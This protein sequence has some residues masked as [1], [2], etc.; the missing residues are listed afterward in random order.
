MSTSV[1]IAFLV[2]AAVALL[3]TPL[4]RQLARN[5]GLV[6]RPAARKVH[7]VAVPYLGG[8]G[9]ASATLTGL[10]FAPGQGVQLGAVA[11]IAVGMCVV[12]LLDDDR[13]LSPRT[14]L[15]V[16]VGA[17]LA[18][19]ALGLRF[20]ATGL[21]AV[22][23]ALTVVWIV[24]LT[25]AVNLL[26]NMDGLGAGTAATVAGSA[27]VVMLGTGG[28]PEAALALAMI[29]ACLGFLVYNKRPATVYMGDA[30]SLFLGYLLAVIT[31]AATEL[32]RPGT[33][34]V[35]PLM[36]AALPVTDTVTVVVARLRRGISPAQAGKDHLSHRLV[37]RGLSPGM[38]V[39]VLLATSLFVGVAG[40]L[41]G[42]GVIPPLV[43]LAA[44]GVALGPLLRV[45][46]A[47]A[48]YD[49]PVLGLPAV[50]RFGATTGILGVAA[51]WVA[52][53]WPEVGKTGE[54]TFLR[55]TASG[56]AHLLLLL[57][58]SAVLVGALASVANRRRMAGEPAP[59]PLSSDLLVSQLK[60]G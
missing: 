36:L 31:L 51:A 57:T 26:D 35:V 18:T 29:G 1:P 30:G 59:L 60:E 41:A 4:F 44:A 38:A 43:A 27:L 49:R 20:E 33:H 11:L 45:V 47:A 15:A 40:A 9:I 46:L 58:A 37:A 14:R 52:G 7:M 2:A 42:L 55:G 22:D 13:Q 6:D 3:T 23:V 16:E 21:A 28:H 10:V 17:A 19:I 5:I 12:G 25:N 24:G 50:V 32:A 54:T 53:I 48:V 56:P 8:L 34:L 39:L